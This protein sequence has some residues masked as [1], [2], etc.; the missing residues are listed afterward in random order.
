MNLFIDQLTTK[1]TTT[2]NGALSHSSTGCSLLDQFGKVATYAKVKRDKNQIHVEMAAIWDENPMLAMKSLFYWRTVTR[3]NKGS[4]ETENVQK[5]QGVRY[6]VFQ[7]LLWVAKNHPKTFYKNLNLIPEFGSWKDLITLWEMDS[8]L[9]NIDAIFALY[10]AVFQSDVENSTYHVENIKKY[11]PTLRSKKNA[12]TLH[13]KKMREF[14][15]AFMKNFGMSEK[16]YRLFKKEGISHKFQRDICAKNFDQLNFSTIG[17]K[18]LPRLTK[19]N[20]KGETFLKRWG[21]ED[22]YIKWIMAKPVANF[23]GYPYELVSRIKSNYNVVEEMT[24]NKQFEMLIQTAKKDNGAIKGNVWCAL[25]T[26]GSMCSSVDGK[27]QV[28]AMDVCM[29]LGIY[30]SSLNEGAFKDN[31]I[32]FDSTSR[33]QK[34]AGSF[35]DK[36]NAL[37]RNAMGSTNFQ[38]V[39][40]EIVRV[41][42]ANPNI[43]VTDFPET[44]LV[45]SDMQFNPAG[46]S[47]T[48]TIY[49]KVN[50]QKMETNYEVA[51]KKLESVGL[52]RITIVWWWVTGRGN[53]Q[54]VRMDDKG[55]ILVGGF[56]GSIISTILGGNKGSKEQMT[57]MDA[58]LLALD[59]E[60]LQHVEV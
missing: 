59:Q 37:P 46:N 53:D 52:P 1:N 25:D 57:P 43:P 19:M 26:S 30:F 20:K 4:F 33:I 32:M 21:L 18:F 45:V 5:G 44:L 56:D 34:L 22:R 3:K 11:L 42:K 39:I 12:N 49:G 28:S 47:Y 31:V 14:V 35:V 8:Q 13:L 54:P 16:E 38:S 27:G 48:D 41:R 58:M 60:L 55:T 10:N 23:T 40:D 51:M 7:R 17:G 24:V 36:Y 29:S 6:E 50:P 9:V 15:N 2:E